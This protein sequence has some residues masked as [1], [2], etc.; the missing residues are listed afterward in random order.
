MKPDI[1]VDI[2]ALRVHADQV[3]AAA[4]AVQ[5]GVDG[6]GHM[7]SHR[8]IYGVLCSPIILPIAAVFEHIAAS[9]FAAA[10]DTTRRI[11]QDLRTTADGYEEADR[12]IARLIAREENP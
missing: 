1:F 6:I 7:S 3:N 4:D 9:A 11:S 5:L 2:E 10:R 8:E 12:H